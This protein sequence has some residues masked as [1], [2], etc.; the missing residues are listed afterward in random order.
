MKSPRLPSLLIGFILLVVSAGTFA[1]GPR[2]RF[3]RESRA[4][5]RLR[6]PHIVSILDFAVDDD[7]HPF[8]VM[9]FLNGL[10]VKDRLAADGPMSIAEIQQIVPPVCMALQFAHD[11]GI[12]HRDLKPANIV[13]H[14][15]APGQQVYK[16]VDAQCAMTEQKVD[17][18]AKQ[19]IESEGSTQVAP[20]ATS[21]SGNSSS[22]GSSGSGSSGSGG[23][24][25]TTPPATATPTT[26]PPIA[27]LSHSGAVSSR[28]R[29]STARM[30]RVKLVP[31]IPASM[32]NAM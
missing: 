12:V 28:K 7:E 27:G 10:S 30:I 3:F 8:L 26:S 4:S 2:E 32:A 29:R 25:Q 24:I 19:T 14:E 11:A 18:A 31:T 9:E 17:G 13:A 1:A 20:G 15:F 6:H 22:S 23:T 21:G 16:L 5:A